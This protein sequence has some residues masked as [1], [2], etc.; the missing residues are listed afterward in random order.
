VEGDSPL[1]HWPELPE[2]FRMWATGPA[3]LSGQ[4]GFRQV[5]QDDATRARLRGILNE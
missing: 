3:V 1:I 2:F 5:A 4:D